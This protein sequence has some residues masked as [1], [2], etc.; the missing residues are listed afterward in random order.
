M[1]D[2][3]KGFNLLGIVLVMAITMIIAGIVL[4]GEDPD[5]RVGKTRDAQRATDVTAISNAINLYTL[6]NDELPPDIADAP[7]EAGTKYVLCDQAAIL[8]CDGQT[9]ECMVVDDQAFLELLGGELPVDPRK[10]DSS[11]TGY[12]ITRDEN[13]DGVIVGACEAY[14]EEE[15][16]N[17]AQAAYPSLVAAAMAHDTYNDF[18]GG[19]M[20][21]SSVEVFMTTGGSGS[22][23]GSGTTASIRLLGDPI[24]GYYGEGSNGGIVSAY[25]FN[26]GYVWIT[27]WA[28]GMIYKVDIDTR[29]VA[30]STSTPKPQY[31]TYDPITHSVWVAADDWSGRL[32][33]FDADDC[34]ELGNWKPYNVPYD[35]LYVSSTVAQSVWSVWESGNMLVQMDP[36]DGTILSTTTI[37][38]NPQDLVYDVTNDAI[39]TFNTVDFTTTK[40]DASD[41]SV[42]DTYSLGTSTTKGAYDPTTESIWISNKDNDTITKMDAS[43]GS[44]TAIYPIGDYPT[45]VLYE[46]YT[47]SI[48]VINK[49]DDNVMKLDPSDGSI[50]GT[51][52]LSGDAYGLVFDS[53]NN[54]IWIGDK[55]NGHIIILDAAT[56]KRINSYPVGTSPNDVMFESYT[57]SIWVSDDDNNVKKINPNTGATIGTYAVGQKPWGMDFDS[58]TNSVWVANF[59]DDTVTKI[60][61]LTGAVVDTY[62][63]ANEPR[64]IVFDPITNSVWV[65]HFD[66]PGLIY[67]LDVTDG[68]FVASTSPGTEIYQSMEFDSHSNSIWAVDRD[69]DVH[70]IDVTDPSNV[71]SYPHGGGYSTQGMTYDPYTNSIWLARDQWSGRAIKMDADDGSILDSYW[72]GHGTVDITFDPVTNSIWAINDTDSQVVKIDPSDGSVV[73]AFASDEVP[74]AIVFDTETN[75][76]WVIDSSADNITKIQNIVFSSSGSVTSNIYDTVSNVAYTTVDWVATTPTDTSIGVKVRTSN[77]SGMS[78]AP[79]F[80]TCTP[81]SNGSDISANNCVTD[82]HQYVQY[83]VSFTTSDDNVSASL[84]SI[85]INFKT[86]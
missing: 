65:G 23:G 28:G 39:W 30:C 56:G 50:R 83:Q 68:S 32:R 76:T 21:T 38:D 80:S 61:A 20:S 52:N 78:G 43:D 26:G 47:D 19:I 62:S 27:N 53:A 73:A 13:N 85:D 22:G 37:G 81:I 84:Q 10:E 46:D 12:Y 2:N 63:V 77:D 66:D 41:G 6:D 36:S 45:S 44:V 51:Y 75:S 69:Y 29:D 60:N 74:V 1:F 42:I 40:V 16:I 71:S 70:K 4:F 3:N 7:M 48:W 82:G 24:D 18:V 49:H 64:G 15:I 86:E 54:R 14:D 25:D 17:R 31:A 67:Q 11:D 72:V 79:E 33:K 9:W 57:G 34:T 55:S 58:Y 35:A 59:D 8:T 5:K